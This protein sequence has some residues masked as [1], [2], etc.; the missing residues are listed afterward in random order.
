MRR[1]AGLGVVTLAF[2]AVGCLGRDAK[3]GAGKGGSADV[4]PVAKAPDAA[5]A[6]APDV[7][8][9]PPT[10]AQEEPDELRPKTH[11]A[12]KG[13]DYKLFPQAEVALD[14]TEREFFKGMG[15]AKTAENVFK[16]VKK[17][18]QKH[19]PFLQRALKSTNREVR[20]QAA[21]MLGLLKDRSEGTITGM[22]A[23]L[24]LDRDPDV[25]AMVGRSFLGV[26]AERATDVLILSLE[27]DPY[28]AA[29]TNAA[30]ALGET[31]DKRAIA[32][33]IQALKDPDTFVRLRTVS[34]LLKFKTKEAVPGLAACLADKSPMVRERALKALVEI[35]G[36]NRGKNPEDWK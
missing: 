3:S 4:P 8:P 35:T 16:A 22:R 13:K 20:I 29:R 17:A 23:A 27:Q 34:A 1:V 25:R 19:I 26:P 31:K 10:A 12:A 30:W 32:P 18:G 28:E 14:D 36:R 24:I 5:V 33:L 6:A 7:P 15:D 21:I 11:P 2:L 9:P